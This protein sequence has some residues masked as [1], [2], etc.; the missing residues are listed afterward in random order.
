MLSCSN[1]RGHRAPVER[2][3]NEWVHFRLGRILRIPQASAPVAVERGANAIRAASAVCAG[4]AC[5]TGDM[6]HV[7]H[8]GSDV[9]NSTEI[10]SEG[11]LMTYHL[12]SQFDIGAFLACYSLCHVAE[13]RYLLRSKRGQI[14]GSIWDN[15]H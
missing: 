8:P 1:F 12:N 5:L 11:T 2:S 7:R 10:Q 4:S 3:G 14:L 13:R 6:Q 9:S 15:R